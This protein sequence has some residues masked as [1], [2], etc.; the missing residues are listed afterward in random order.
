MVYFAVAQPRNTTTVGTLRRVLRGDATG[1]T[2]GG[3]I[4]A[5]RTRTY[6]GTCY[7]N[8]GF[9][10]HPAGRQRTRCIKYIYPLAAGRKIFSCLEL[11]SSLVRRRE[12]KV[13]RDHLYAEVVKRIAPNS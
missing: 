12:I 5:S 4:N 2:V 8:Q 11:N 1:R 9:A 10:L 6:R 7:L 3:S 13:E